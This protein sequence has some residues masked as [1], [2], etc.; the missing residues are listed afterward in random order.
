MGFRAFDPD[1][2]YKVRFYL[3]HCSEED[4][5]RAMSFDLL[6]RAYERAGREAPDFPKL[7]FA[8]VPRRTYNE[9]ML[10]AAEELFPTT[11]M[12]AALAALGRGMYPHFAGSMIGKA[13]FSVAGHHLPAI[14]RLA[15]RAYAVSNGRGSVDAL[16]AREGLVHLRYTDVWDPIPFTCG[17]WLGGLELCSIDTDLLEIEVRGPVDYDVRVVY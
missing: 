13:I 6:R 4:S 11:T 5:V 8:K 3:D 7:P 10:R 17:V 1:S 15:P 12:A 9:A 14:G 16:H 2:D